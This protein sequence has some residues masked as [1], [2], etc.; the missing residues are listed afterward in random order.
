MAGVG[1]A[2]AVISAL[3]AAA[4]VGMG[5]YNIQHPPKVPKMPTFPTAAMEAAPADSSALQLQRSRQRAAMA[6]TRSGTLLT[7]PLGLSGGSTGGTAT[8]LG[9]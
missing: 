4:S 5:V 6:G 9:S 1:E 8:L 3:S 7:G 2:A